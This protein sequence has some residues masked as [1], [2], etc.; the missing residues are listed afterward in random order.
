MGVAEK[1]AGAI[2]E[3]GGRLCEGQVEN[4]RLQACQAGGDEKGGISRG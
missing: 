3:S 1:Y 4:G 2:E